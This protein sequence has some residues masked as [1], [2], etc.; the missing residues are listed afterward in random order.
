MY[1]WRC[2]IGHNLAHT[3]VTTVPRALFEQTKAKLWSTA[4]KAA[5]LKIECERLRAELDE[6]RGY[7]ESADAK[8]DRL[9][10]LC[11]HAHTEAA[12]LSAVELDAVI[13]EPV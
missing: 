8:V 6:V 10:A 3:A 5:G 7:L 11:V 13:D 4:S 12:D 2:C 1:A 9:N